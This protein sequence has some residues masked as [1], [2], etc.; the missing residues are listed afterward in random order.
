MAN[1]AEIIT[2]RVIEQLQK[3]VAPWRK[4]WVTKDR[5]WA[6][7]FIS[8]KPYRGC[9]QM[10]LQMMGYSSPFWLTF[11]QAAELGGMVRKGEKGTPI[12]Y[13]GTAKGKK[14]DNDEQ[15]NYTFLRYS[16]VFNV[17]QCERL[18]LPVVEAPERRHDKIEAA[19][20]I[21]AGYKN[22]PT[23]GHADNAWYKVAADRVGIPNLDEFDSPDTYYATMFHELAHSTGH[24][25]R[26]KRDGIVDQIKFGSEQYGKE[27][28]VAE[29]TAAFLCAESGIDCLTH[30]ASYCQ[31]WITTLQGDAKLVI[32]A[33]AA[34][35]KAY[36]HIL[37]KEVA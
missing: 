33:A 21:C 28:L 30:N 4:P 31:S 19:E 10:L 24:E 13:V 9:N 20:A 23:V 25:S 36:E 22:P 7:N 8:R 34:A 26:L 15:V 11:K 16:T 5:Q 2:A 18:E 35:Q 17:E 6:A 12:I 27:E 37:G 3:G 29:L 14:T 32:S 1:V